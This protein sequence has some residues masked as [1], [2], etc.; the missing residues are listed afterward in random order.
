MYKPWAATRG[1]Y[2]WQLAMI[3]RPNGRT[4]L[5][6]LMDANIHMQ[7]LGSYAVYLQ[8]SRTLSY[9]AVWIYVNINWCHVLEIL[10]WNEIFLKKSEIPLEGEKFF[11][12]NFLEK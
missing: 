11:G 7:V 12:M 6:V 10:G 3:D 8:I 1:N 9:D 2:R 5:P 4:V